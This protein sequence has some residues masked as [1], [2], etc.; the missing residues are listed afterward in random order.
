MYLYPIDFT[1]YYRHQKSALYALG[2]C[3]ASMII[4]RP[5]RPIGADSSGVAMRLGAE[6]RRRDRPPTVLLK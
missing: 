4:F 5:G 1:Q 3:A 2:A 6:T